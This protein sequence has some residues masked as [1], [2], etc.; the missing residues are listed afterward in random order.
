MSLRKRSWLSYENKSPSYTIELCNSEMD[1]SWVRRMWHDLEG[2]KVG[3]LDIHQVWF[4]KEHHWKIG[5]FLHHW[6]IGVFFFWSIFVETYKSYKDWVGS[7][8]LFFKLCTKQVCSLL[9]LIAKLG[10]LMLSTW[11]DDCLQLLPT[12]EQ[13]NF[14]CAFQW[15]WPFIARTNSIHW[16]TPLRTLRHL[17]FPGILYLKLKK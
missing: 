5:V 3:S 14:P 15:S 13:L 2:G 16:V 7:L 1:E 6:K 17:R 10:D 9:I 4:P 12:A 11:R 8:F